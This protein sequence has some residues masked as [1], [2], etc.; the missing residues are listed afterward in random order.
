MLGFLAGLPGKLKTLTDRLTSGR[1]AN[2]DNLDAAMT[3]R[4]AASTALSTA[5]WTNA[6]A[7]ALLAVKQ[8]APTSYIGNGSEIVTITYGIIGAAFALSGWTTANVLKT[9]RSETGAG[10]LNLV[11][12]TANNTTARTIRVKV[13]IDGVVVVDVTS[14]SINSNRMGILPIG[15]LASWNDLVYENASVIPAKLAYNTSLLVEYASSL[16]ETDN[17][18]TYIARE[19]H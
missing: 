1:A 18:R 15:S 6:L 12:V 11:A 14:I 16:T 3:S 13:T 19:V 7:A 10:V 4:A 2:L 8:R 9:L 17:L 5:Q